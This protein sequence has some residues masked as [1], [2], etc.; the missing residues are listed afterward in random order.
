MDNAV[1]LMAYG[2]PNSLEDVEPY[3]LDVRGGRET[4]AELVHEVRSRY[5]QIGGRSP[6]LEITS[7]QADALEKCLRD[8][9]G[10]VRVYVGM[11]HWKP[12]IQEVVKQIYQD[13]FRSIIALCMAPYFSRMSVGAYRDKLQ[14]ALT[15]LPQAGQDMKVRL[16]ESWHDHPLFIQAIVAKVRDAL[17][18][19]PEDR[20]DA[21]RVVFTAHSLPQAIMKQGD[22]YAQHHAETAALAAEA[23]G[24]PAERWQI[25]YQSAPVQGKGPLWLTPSLEETLETLVAEGV[26][27]VLIAPIGFVAD[28]VEILYDVDI[29]AQEQAHTLGLHLERIDSMNTS[30]SFIEALADLV[31]EQVVAQDQ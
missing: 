27:D 25:G 10:K 15:S 21:V 7:A 6:L 9:P 11:R 28:H 13:G 4:P 20:R 31:R 17:A 3:L 14:A 5:E 23:L 8:E 29:D 22:P 19:F 2:G 26:Q 12:Y 18:H 24:L 1:L 30:T 16:V